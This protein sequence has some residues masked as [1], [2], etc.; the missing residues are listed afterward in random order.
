MPS[1]G[2]Q[3]VPDIASG[4]QQHGQQTEQLLTAG[5]ST[6]NGRPVPARSSAQRCRQWQGRFTSWRACRGLD[7]GEPGAEIDSRRA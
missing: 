5:A 4:G 1:S 3:R 7:E 6:A 2:G